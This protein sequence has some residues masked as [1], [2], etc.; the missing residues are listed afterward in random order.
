MNVRI[1][2]VSLLLFL[3]WLGATSPVAAQRVFPIKQNKKWGL[4]NADGQLVQPAIY[5]AIGE[6]R[7]FGYAI[8]QRQGRV[9]LLGPDGR[10]IIPPRYD[11]LKVLDSLF[12]SVL[13]DGRWEVL[14]L[15]GKVI[16][17]KG[18]DQVRV[19]R[20]GSWQALAFSRDNRWGLVD[21]EGRLVL[22]PIFDDLQVWEDEGNRLERTYLLSSLH[23][24]S[25]L[26]HTTGEPILD[27][28]ADVIVPLDDRLFMA[29]LGGFWGAV[30]ERGDELIPARFDHFSTIGD[31]FLRLVAQGK[32]S[33]FSRVYNRLIVENRHDGYFQ[34]SDE[35]V[36]CRKNR[37]IGLVDHCGQEVLQPQYEE[38]QP[39]ANDVFRVRY[40]NKWGLLSL[41]DEPVLPF[42][43][44]YIAPPKDV[45][46]TVFRETKKGVVNTYG[47]LVLEPRFD[48]VEMLPGQV[49]GFRGSNLTVV[50]VDDRGWPLDSSDVGHF[51]SIRLRNSHRRA[52]RHAEL[53]N[54][55]LLSKFEWFYSTKSNKWGLRRL[56]N[57]EVQIQPSFH[58]LVV[59]QNPNL[60]L[61]G[62]DM[63]TPVVFDRTTFRFETAW[64]LVQNDTG[65][66]VHETNLVDIRLEDFEAGLPVAR[67]VFTDGRHGLVNRIGKVLIKDLTWVGP[68]NEGLAPVAVGGNLS[69]TYERTTPHTLGLLRDY[70]S[71]L[72]S[73]AS[74]VDFTIH[75][76][77]IEN[78]GKLFCQ[79]C[80]WGYIDTTGRFIIA[81][82]YS[83]ARPVVNE[84]CIVACDDKWGMLHKQG[85]QLLPCDFDELEFVEHTGNKVLHIFRREHRY[86]LLDS[87]GQ[88][89]LDARFED[90]GSFSEGL[91][92]VKR[93]GRWGYVDRNGLE[94]IPCRFDEVSPFSEGLAAVRMGT[95]WGYIDRNG[96]TELGFEFSKAGPFSHGLAPA[97]REGPYFGYIDRQG[98]W[99]IEPTFAVTH[100]FDR[101]VAVVE[102]TTGEYRRAGLIDTQGTF[103]VKPRYLSI[104][105]FDRHGLAVVAQ[106][107]NP[108]RYGLI[109]LRGK[110]ICT[111]SWRSIAPFSEGLAR[112]Q[113]D[114]RYGYIDTTGKLVIP[115]IFQKAGHFSEGKAAVWING[116]CGYIDR[117]GELVI[118]PAYTRCMDFQDD[119]AIVFSPG[120]RAGL[121]DADG[122][123]LIPPGTDRILEFSE[124]RGLVRNRHYQFYYIT[125]QNRFFD[126]YY[127]K[128]GG[129]THGMAVVKVDDRWAIINQQGIEIIPPKYDRIER[130]ENGFAKVRIKG[131]NGLT[132]L[133]GE[134]IIQPDYEYINYA[135][136]G[137]FRVEKGDKIGY[138]DL[139]GRW[140]WGLQE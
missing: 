126:G 93:N 140:V 13:R 78:Q 10:E 101:G 42:E 1:A 81:T 7:H 133:K 94:V 27:P 87:L 134:L 5:D 6:F 8:M 72:L 76:Q 115:A 33:L 125:E 60:T 12:I 39:F 92:A 30:N 128:A 69:A 75:D 74:L 137:L 90:I 106:P 52:V 118:A 73:T 113:L 32:Q 35:Y 24:R 120:M 82:A 26:L 3:T 46:T 119:R 100:P 61:V 49:R 117:R 16:L 108:V 31:H 29:K 96:D 23:G 36:L 4:M 70:L 95:R 44:D 54:P 111:P 15:S 62:V 14:T 56:D 19:L 86:G 135:G 85:K 57:G 91:L 105:P 66:L 131:F 17:S 37:K 9:G 139:D 28:V 114:D 45:L 97:K 18:Y 59:L 112:V 99:A 104:E 43:Y 124:G 122:Q 121:I 11:D 80:R 2:P 107:G 71:K 40:R 50:E 55:Y 102:M 79:D 68:F 136:E 34:F 110:V 47:F 48:R 41:G 65:L 51:F 84:V 129:F 53:E 88:L 63:L 132:N 25:G 89:A 38:V 77:R 83:F 58:H 22:E 64:G 67:C 103:I 123:V 98:Q 109:D 21:V 130:F 20:K 127:E 116:Q 138:F